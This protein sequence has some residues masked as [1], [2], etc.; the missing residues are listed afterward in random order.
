MGHLMLLALA[1]AAL[2]LVSLVVHPMRPC[3]RCAQHAAA[4]GGSGRNT[5]SSKRRFGACGRCGG[6]GTARR[7]GAKTVHKV[8]LRASKARRERKERP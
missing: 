2:W 8:I 3:P 4:R 5:G 7:I 1:A 6:T